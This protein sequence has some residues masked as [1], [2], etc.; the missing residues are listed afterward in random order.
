MQRILVVAAAVV[1]TVG[2]SAA[3]AGPWVNPAGSGDHF[4]YANGGDLNGHFGEPFVAGDQFFFT[5]ANFHVYAENG[6]SDTQDDTVSFDVFANPDWQFSLVRVYAFGSYAVTSGEG[7]DSAGVDAGLS[8][9]EIDG[10]Q[11]TYAGDLVTTPAMPVD[12]EASGSW[13][14]LAVVDVTNEFP[15]VDDSMHIEMTNDV[16]A[17]SSASGSAEINVQYQDFK[18]EFTMIPEPSSLA[19]LALGGLA[20]MRRRR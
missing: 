9:T 20:L 10:L 2:A 4:T 1:L 8:L 18:I 5:Q 14:G 7:T 11:R 13:S 6:A 16:L 12:Y 17:I 19:L 3:L 15:A